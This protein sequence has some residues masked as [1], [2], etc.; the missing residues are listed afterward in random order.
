MAHTP[1]PASTSILVSPPATSF[2]GVYL[3]QRH[4]DPWLTVVAAT[5]VLA[6]AMPVLLSHVPFHPTLTFT[7]HIVGSA[8]ACIILLWMIGVVLASMWIPAPDVPVVPDTLAGVLWYAKASEIMEVVRG[9]ALLSMK[10]RNRHVEEKSLRYSLR[11]GRVEVER[12]MKPGQA[13]REKR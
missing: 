12:T 10:D 11:A 1:Q 13:E 8:S 5:A 2:S 7:V 4:G 9:T 6:T 3:A